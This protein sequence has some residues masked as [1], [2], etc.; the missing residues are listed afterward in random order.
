MPFVAADTVPP[1]WISSNQ[2]LVDVGS[3]TGVSRQLCDCAPAGSLSG[4]IALVAAGA[5]RTA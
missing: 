5:V 3:I 4:A 1:S 2:R